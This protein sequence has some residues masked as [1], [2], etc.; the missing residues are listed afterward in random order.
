MEKFDFYIRVFSNGDQYLSSFF[1]D[2]S[3]SNL[4]YII[5]QLGHSAL[6]LNSF[7]E[8]I[9]QVQK[10]DKRS[11][12]SYNTLYVYVTDEY[13]EVGQNDFKPNEFQKISTEIVI[14]YIDKAILYFEKYSNGDIPGIIPDSKK[15]DW[16]IVPKESVNRE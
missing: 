12:V 5:D 2:N 1:L 16:I 13:C 7:K 10:N 11:L 6:E 15:D 3:L 14:D 9:L 4:I 8:R